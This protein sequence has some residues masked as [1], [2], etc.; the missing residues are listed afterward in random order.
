ML[1]SCALIHQNKVPAVYVAEIIVY[2]VFKALCHLL[3]MG[4][5]ANFFY[6]CSAHFAV[7]MTL[8]MWSPA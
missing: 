2:I 7:F 5:L 4:N 8:H 1:H 6:S 3:E